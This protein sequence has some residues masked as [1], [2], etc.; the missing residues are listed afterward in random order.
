MTA[1]IKSTT[2]PKQRVT[3]LGMADN[4]PILT[5]AD[6]RTILTMPEMR[7]TKI[8]MSSQPLAED[9]LINGAMI[10]GVMIN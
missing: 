1:K 9:Q 4:R 10:N 6:N 3:A 7:A 2:Y 5:Y 8:E